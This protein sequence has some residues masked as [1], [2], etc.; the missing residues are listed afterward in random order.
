MWN[1]MSSTEKKQAV[2]DMADYLKTNRPE[3]KFNNEQL[4][5]MMDEAEN[6]YKGLYDPK[7]IDKLFT[8]KNAL[9]EHISD[10][11]KKMDDA[12]VSMV[13]NGNWL[14]IKI[15][16]I[17]WIK[18][19]VFED[20]DKLLTEAKKS[21]WDDASQAD[22]IAWHDANKA[23]DVKMQQMIQYAVW[24]HS[25]DWD[26]MVLDKSKIEANQPLHA[27]LFG[28]L[29]SAVK[30]I[31]LLDKWAS[32]EDMDKAMENLGMAVTELQKNFSIG[33]FRSY[34]TIID[35]ANSKIQFKI[36]IDD[37]GELS[38][39]QWKD[40]MDLISEWKVTVS[41][42]KTYEWQTIRA[43]TY[44]VAGQRSQVTFK[45][46][47]DKFLDSKVPEVVE[48]VKKYF[49]LPDE[50]YLDAWFSTRKWATAD[51]TNISKQFLFDMRALLDGW[52][53]DL[54]FL[55]RNKNWAHL[56]WSQLKDE[57]MP[58]LK[59]FQNF[60]QKLAS[61][62]YGIENVWNKWTRIINEFHSLSENEQM[63]R[64]GESVKV[65]NK[66]YNDQT[67]LIEYFETQDSFINV[68]SWAFW[69]KPYEQWKELKLTKFIH[70]PDDKI[71]TKT[72]LTFGSETVK[73]FPF[74]VERAKAIATKTEE[75]DIKKVVAYVRWTSEKIKDAIH[76]GRN[77]DWTFDIVK[78]LSKV[79]ALES[80]DKVKFFVDWELDEKALND[81]IKS[82]ME[83]CHMPNLW[84]PHYSNFVKLV[85][86]AVRGMWKEMEPMLVPIIYNFAYKM[87]Y[88]K[89]QIDALVKLMDL[90]WGKEFFDLLSNVM[91]DP[92][93][94]EPIAKRIKYSDS[95]VLAAKVKAVA[96]EE[97]NK[98]YD[99]LAARKENVL[100]DIDNLSI[101]RKSQKD[102]YVKTK[103]DVKI[104]Q[105]KS[106]VHAIDRAMEEWKEKFVNARVWKAITEGNVN[107]LRSVADT[108]AFHKTMEWKLVNLEKT[109]VWSA[110]EQIEKELSI[111]KRI[112][113]I[114]YEWGISDEQKKKINDFI[115]KMKQ[116]D[117][118]DK[119]FLLKQSNPFDAEKEKELH[120][121][122]NHYV[123][124]FIQAYNWISVYDTEAWKKMLQDY[125]TWEYSL[126]SLANENP[127]QISIASL[128]SGNPYMFNADVHQ[129]FIDEFS[130]GPTTV[131]ET[132]TKIVPVFEEQDVSKEIDENISAIEKRI[133]ELDEA[134]SEWKIDLV[135]NEVLFVD[136]EGKKFR[137]NDQQQEWIEKIRDHVFKE[138]N[139]MDVRNNEDVFV[140]IGAGWTWKT[141]IITKALLWDPDLWIPWITSSRINLI[142]PTHKALKALKE[143]SEKSWLKL[144][145]ENYKTVAS[146][147]GL[148]LD[149]ETGKFKKERDTETNWNVFIIDESS[150]LDEAQLQ[151]L[152]KNCRTVENAKIIFL[153]D[154]LQLWP[155]VKEVKWKES[156]KEWIPPV[157]TKW[158]KWHKLTQVMRQEWENAILD[159][160]NVIRDNLSSEN[161]QFG[162]PK[163]LLVNSDKWWKK[164]RIH[165]NVS[166]V[167]KEYWDRFKK[168][169]KEW[170]GLSLRY[171][172]YTNKNV[173]DFNNLIRSVIW[174]DKVNNKINEW[175]V[176]MLWSR[177]FHNK[178]P[179]FESSEEVIVEKLVGKTTYKISPITYAEITQ[180]EIDAWVEWIVAHA[181]QIKLKW[182]PVPITMVFQELDWAIKIH[183]YKWIKNRL[184]EYRNKGEK[185]K[186]LKKIANI[187]WLVYAWSEKDLQVFARDE[188]WNIILNERWAEV[189]EP[190]IPFEYWYA[191]TSHKAQW[192]TM[193]TTI[194]DY[195]N[196]QEMA[197]NKW[198]FDS[199]NRSLY[200][201]VSRPRNE[202]ALIVPGKT[203][204]DNK[205]I[206]DLQRKTEN[207]NSEYFESVK[208]KKSIEPQ[209]TERQKLESRLEELRNEPRV[210][211]V[212]TWTKEETHEVEKVIP[213]NKLGM[214][215]LISAYHNSPKFKAVIDALHVSDS[216]TE[217]V[218]GK[219]VI[220][221]SKID[222]RNKAI[223]EL[224]T[225]FKKA[226][227]WTV[228]VNGEDVV[229]D[230]VELAFLDWKTKIKWVNFN[231]WNI[232]EK[233]ADIA[234]NR[235]LPNWDVSFK[236]ID[237]DPKNKKVKRAETKDEKW[238]SYVERVLQ[239]EVFESRWVTMYRLRWI[240]AEEIGRIRVQT[241]ASLASNYWDQKTTINSKINALYDLN[242]EKST[243]WLQDSITGKIDNATATK[244]VYVPQIEGLRLV[245]QKLNGIE[246]DLNF[247]VTQKEIKGKIRDLRSDAEDAIEETIKA[248]WIDS[249]N[250]VLM[251]GIGDK[252]W[253]I[254][255]Y[256]AEEWFKEKFWARA[257]VLLAETHIM[258][259]GGYFRVDPSIDEK[260]LK[261]A[262]FDSFD[263]YAEYVNDFDSFRNA[264]KERFWAEWMPSTD[265]DKDLIYE[266]L[267]FRDEYYTRN[268]KNLDAVKIP[269]SDKQKPILDSKTVRKRE[270]PTGSNSNT[271]GWVKAKISTYIM[272]EVHPDVPWVF[273]E[274][275]IKKIESLLDGKASDADCK[276]YLDYYVPKILKGVQDLQSS[277]NQQYEWLSELW[278]H[279]S[280]VI[281]KTVARWEREP[282]RQSLSSMLEFMKN[283]YLKDQQDGTSY[284]SRWLWELRASI[285]W[286]SVWSFKDHM[287]WM[288]KRWDKALGNFL[289]K[290]L[291]NVKKI[292]DENGKEIQMAALVW[293]SS[294]KLKWGFVKYDKPK[295]FRANWKL[296]K[297]IWE[298][299][300]TDTSFFKNAATDV[301]EHAEDLTMS[302][303]IKSHMSYP[304]QK[305]IEAIQDEQVRQILQ[306]LKMELWDPKI[307]VK[308]GWAINQ[309]NMLLASRTWVGWGTDSVINAKIQNAIMEIN[310]VFEKPK[311]EWQSFFIEE[312]STHIRPTQIIVHQDAPMVKLIREKQKALLDTL[313]K[314]SNDYKILKWEYDNYRWLYTSGFR[315]P[316]PSNFWVWG[317]E[318]IVAKHYSE[319]KMY[320]V[321]G[322]MVPKEIW[323]DKN[324]KP[325][326]ETFNPYEDLAK[327][328]VV[329]HPMPA[330]AKH[331]GDFD[332]DHLWL[333]SAHEPFWGIVARS[334]LWLEP[335]DDPVKKMR[336]DYTQDEIEEMA[337]W[338]KSKSIFNKLNGIKNDFIVVSQVEKDSNQKTADKI[339][340]NISQR[341]KA[342]NKHAWYL[343]LDEQTTIA[344]DAKSNVGIVAASI[345]TFEQL[346]YLFKKIQNVP[347]WSERDKLLRQQVIIKWRDED[348]V[349]KDILVTYK[350]LYDEYGDMVLD[351]SFAAIASSILQ[352]TV[353]FWAS[354]LSEFKKDWAAH[355]A[356]ASRA[357]SSIW[358]EWK[359]FDTKLLQFVHDV[360]SPMSASY[361]KLD[362]KEPYKIWMLSKFITDAAN[363]DAA[364]KVEKFTKFKSKIWQASFDEEAK[365]TVEEE[366]YSDAIRSIWPRR[367]MI[368]RLLE[369]V[370]L[371]DWSVL[372]FW[373]LARKLNDVY[374][375]TFVVKEIG[376]K[377][378]VQAI[379]NFCENT[380]K[381]ITS[382]KD[383]KFGWDPKSEFNL[384]IKKFQLKKLE[385]A[386]I[387]LSGQPWVKE[388]F[389][390]WVFKKN[391]NTWEMEPV[392]LLKFGSK[393][394]TYLSPDIDMTFKNYLE[395]VNSY[396]EWKQEWL[397]ASTSD[398]FKVEKY[399][400]D[401][402]ILNNFD[403][404]QLFFLSM[405]SLAK[406][407]KK[408]ASKLSEEFKL[409]Y[410][411]SSDVTAKKR[412]AWFWIDFEKPYSIEEAIGYV[413]SEIEDE[414]FGLKQLAEWYDRDV[415]MVRISKLED[416][417]EYMENT[418]EKFKEKAEIERPVESRIEPIDD[419]IP[420]FI[421][422]IAYET[423]NLSP[424]AINDMSQWF[425][426]LKSLS[427]EWLKL[428]INSLWMKYLPN[429]YGTYNAFDD[430]LNSPNLNF[431]DAAFN[432]F[433]EFGEKIFSRNNIYWMIKSSGLTT[434][435][436][437]K[438]WK[439]LQSLTLRKADGKWQ[440]VS[441]D[442]I[443]L[444]ATKAFK[445][446]PEILALLEKE[447]FVNKL[448]TYVWKTIDK[449]CETLNSLESIQQVDFKSAYEKDMHSLVTDVVEMYKHNPQLALRAEWISTRE[450][451]EALIQTNAM[452]ID[453]PIMKATKKIMSDIA[454]WRK[455]DFIDKAL[456][457]VQWI[458][459]ELSYGTAASLFT[460]NNMYAWLSQMIPNYVE[461]RSYASKHSAILK[462]AEKLRYALWLLDSE[463]VLRSGTGH[464]MEL[465]QTKLAQTI[466]SITKTWVEK[467]TEATW[468]LVNKATWLTVLD[469]KKA[470][471]AW[472]IV[473]NFTNN[474]L[475][476]NDWPLES[477]RKTVAIAQTME[478]WNLSSAKE[479]IEMLDN[480]WI[481]V[482]NNFR[483]HV[484]GEFINSWG[485]VVSW[486][487]WRWT[488]FEYSYEY[489]GPLN[490]F[491]T[492]FAMKSFGYLMNWS[493]H[494]M[495]VFAEKESALVTWLRM[496]VQWD[497][498]WWLAHIEDFFRYNAMLTKQLA[499]SAG[500]YL[501][502]QKY[503]HDDKDRMTFSSFASSFNNSIVAFE[504][505]FGQ[506]IK[507]WQIWSE[508]GWTWDAIG[509]T[510][511]GIINRMFRLFK[512]PAFIS[513][514]YDKYR[515][516]AALGN[517]DMWE[518]LMYAMDKHYTS[519]MRISW[520]QVL[521][522]AYNTV[523]AKSNLGI[524]WTGW[525]TVEDELFQDLMDYKTYANWK[526]NWTFMSVLSWFSSII[527]N[528]NTPIGFKVVQDMADKINEKMESD[529][530]LRKLK[531]GWEIGT[532]PN[533]YDIANVIGKSWS[534]L[535]EMEKNAVREIWKSVSYWAYSAVDSAWH[536]IKSDWSEISEAKNQEL[537][538]R[539]ID[540]ALKKT[541][542]D[543]EQLISISPKD[544]AF[545]KTIATLELNSNLKT[546]TVIAAIM[547]I[548]QVKM[549]NDLKETEWKWTWILYGKTEWRSLT[550]DQEL[551]IKQKILTE[552][553]KYLNLDSTL[554]W[555]VIEQHVKTKYSDVFDKL[556][557]I[558]NYKNVQKQVLDTL[559]TAQL[560]NSNMRIYWDVSSVTKL[561]SRYAVAMR[562]LKLDDE[563]WVQVA[564]RWMNQIEDV[565]WMDKKSK[566]AHQASVIYSMDKAQYGIMKDNERFNEL[567]EDAQ[568]QLTNWLYKV[569]SESLDF[570]SESYIS[571]MNAAVSKNNITK[572][573]NP[574]YKS[575]AFSWQRP[576]FSKQFAPLKDMLK[577]KEWMLGYDPNGY[578]S[579]VRWA[580]AIP[581]GINQAQMPVMRDY[582]REI[583]KQTF[584]GYDSKWVVKTAQKEF[585]AQ[586]PTAR[587][588]KIKKAKVAKANKKF[589]KQPQVKIPKQVSKWL[590]G[591]M[592]IA[593][594][595]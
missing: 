374:D 554:V 436:T 254:R 307:K 164:V 211:T 562:W 224:K 167:V 181:M 444:K 86:T 35:A 320:E 275:D 137:A 200:V 16:D 57:L 511:F 258:I 413:R 294:M 377:S 401:Q 31:K 560:V 449:V 331:E 510:T 141:T 116:A 48:F 287:F 19:E 3:I 448:Q 7:E 246:L 507:Q 252:N 424:Q 348:W 41:E 149:E 62:F 532:W 376:M 589:F 522:D 427:Q 383:W 460:Q 212:Q 482:E 343:F 30:E 14:W 437:E 91:L 128:I 360:I 428:T 253:N 416:E 291:F 363:L 334:A 326:Y 153:W 583:W 273:S 262:W 299:E 155:I 80:T 215:T 512:Q 571:K 8:T 63:M 302:N 279:V 108:L 187:L 395:D 53:C 458:H 98:Y 154:S 486:G 255:V 92:Q 94:Y 193:D 536:R 56:S 544:P 498:K 28:K 124:D 480:R 321:D 342:K 190:I 90:K 435:Q 577:G 226:F 183:G 151:D 234:N 295:F 99:S 464:G 37:M 465:N 59:D 135:E 520:M 145:D 350:D 561:Q 440:S 244:T 546:P 403:D 585:G 593:N 347:E 333:L 528:E 216:D 402:K 219:V 300:W 399:L 411:V 131:K 457:F 97:W 474:M 553:Q 152:I 545:L 443:K 573:F 381:E 4:R 389:S 148:M 165:N 198:D 242:F 552:Y 29:T 576:N 396:Y 293:E 400:F 452:A 11:L 236:P 274:S 43:W 558:D 327:T 251:W 569:S 171:I 367:D 107:A 338:V 42:D 570:D 423:I 404:D 221:Q 566:L 419:N 22:I 351:E 358:W 588:V 325:I 129:K 192:S 590:I 476:F 359:D 227:A 206:P 122:V 77:S 304:L 591:W 32:Q 489:L 209:I 118:K 361:R 256:V 65:W 370:E 179:L 180:Q 525:A 434:E 530:E 82:I 500:I 95:N 410:T 271:F 329:M 534:S 15:E 290:T 72:Y 270:G 191:S 340:E 594:Y 204:F 158:Y 548:K 58:V 163:E 328:S 18:K 230:M 79:N 365:M 162:V 40:I 123:D 119:M 438:A 306:K 139:P 213:P 222:E 78:W 223:T 516:D 310:N 488:L 430:F 238:S 517:P 17:T 459:Y 26:K 352:V 169:V 394:K 357:W 272:A 330:Y 50:H 390:K 174:W 501:K 133:A 117:S 259:W 132:V 445:E 203:Y 114:A 2:S 292:E 218:N 101:A 261:D 285:Q 584:Y 24:N 318:I 442:E 425:V 64:W 481:K 386:L 120:E 557:K 280:S 136:K 170:N 115:K 265:T 504:I 55:Q 311:E 441:M 104:K 406:W 387:N 138:Y 503:E 121:I 159:I 109:E 472:E 301:E 349:R 523:T 559:K 572:D 214:D 186:E 69:I 497:A 551:Q 456:A 447:D 454:F 313:D 509:Y 235:K 373:K 494:K 140:L 469:R 479:A 289:G 36:W 260:V 210:K 229:D 492:R 468:T 433:D 578:L 127:V 207:I 580:S 461:L 178:K 286:T 100:R 309:L 112:D 312:V 247:P 195:E 283:V 156:P 208:E 44:K 45:N 408:I 142:A 515:A 467:I 538:E 495:A 166:S 21:I 466:S 356:K 332:G 9:Y 249:K 61:E 362:L 415:A 197:L 527:K 518:A 550:S 231:G 317:Y 323:K 409:Q 74:V 388:L 421:P 263:Q 220:K 344:V 462:E 196:I 38:D 535:S 587:E 25:L 417:L 52:I 493:F 382:N 184:Y 67:E 567:T 20:A 87:A 257:T 487:I 392:K 592:P 177:V 453:K 505:L 68:N 284:A 303:Q 217:T 371:D 51:S 414:K 475:W 288:V 296:I 341:E 513:T 539:Q 582:Q 194:V 130:T 250:S 33:K 84:E 355:M 455:L 278:D 353:D 113:K 199:T 12:K 316:V 305:M 420:Y 556:D 173:R 185:W 150:M 146:F 543:M 451:F 547:K 463:N 5:S 432:H 266:M 485:W 380:I 161:M 277:W 526:R 157:F 111:R 422:D 579:A 549:E 565:P 541:W 143:S 470:I 345:R 398:M 81:A 49:P 233:L 315:Y 282:Y 239:E 364:W 188:G 574:H 514:A 337:K 555:S 369:D 533:N 205:K 375:S 385:D 575:K 281:Q 54:K 393:W 521:D 426:D 89:P 268:F 105:M 391:L 83:K 88:H 70:T 308:A 134:K 106:V 450:Q 102:Y 540:K 243:E 491:A 431:Y 47:L 73:N 13:L 586:K 189:K 93:L 368:F 405:W 232:I 125:Y 298:V 506:H 324:G 412:L 378:D 182:A 23:L 446:R 346:S 160:A 502:F 384:N 176:L 473:D 379:R 471:F 269:L 96:T 439:L 175:E 322:K 499:F 314:E 168:E 490:N 478:K 240:S 429:F 75:W 524:L 71:S 483:S 519:Y 581:F 1:F 407:D 297:I 201:W 264:F 237:S 595:E 496:M 66:T 508:F 267:A 531:N 46:Q 245:M 144:A 85:H 336:P 34:V 418:L 477:L 248:M 10:N 202:L 319:P 529:K 366:M 147:N 76:Y 563:T 335:A 276:E 172:S 339:A 228:L 537:L 27:E 103:Y 568:R 372:N 225:F 564:L 542:I 39:L 6:L 354:W 241:K 126:Q 60:M 110:L 397:F 484:R